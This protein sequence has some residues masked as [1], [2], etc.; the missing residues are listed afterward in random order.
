LTAGETAAAIRSMDKDALSVQ[1]KDLIPGTICYFPQCQ[2]EKISI[3]QHQPN[4]VYYLKI[5]LINENG[6]KIIYKQHHN[7]IPEVGWTWNVSMVL[8]KIMKSDGVNYYYGK[9]PGINLAPTCI[10]KRKERLRARRV[11]VTLPQYK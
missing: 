10:E 6:D 7:T 5:K 8:E 1:T 4:D 9:K 2:I 11:P 3:L